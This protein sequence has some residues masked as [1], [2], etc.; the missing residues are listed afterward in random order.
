MAVSIIFDI[1]LDMFFDMFFACGCAVTPEGGA[2]N[3]SALARPE[4]E[5]PNPTKR[6]KKQKQ[7][8]KSRLKFWFIWFIWFP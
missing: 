2:Q 8:K 6:G 1:I 3:A 7:N 5:A 4:A